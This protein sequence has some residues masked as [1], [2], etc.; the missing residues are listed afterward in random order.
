MNGGIVPLLLIGFSVGLMLA[1]APGRVMKG[2]LGALCGAAIVGF[3]LFTSLPATLTFVGLW[4]TTIAV[5][6]TSYL[7]TARWPT[8]PVILSSLAGLSLGAC[9]GLNGDYRGLVLGLLVAFV[10]YP[11]KWLAARKLDIVIKVVASWMIAIASLS[12]FV[13]LMATP[14]YKPDHME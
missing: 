6:A 3:F 9:A 10:C 2:A 13:S 11:A 12:M 4:T 5:A 14:G 7:P 8:L 1:F